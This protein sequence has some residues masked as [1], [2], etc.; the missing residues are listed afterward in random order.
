MKPPVEAPTSRQR[1]PLD[2]E[3]ELLQRVG[4]LD[5]AARDEARR[6]VDRDLDV[7][8]DELAGLLR[9]LAARADAHLPRHHGRSGA[10][11]R[12]EQA[13]LG[14]EGVKAHAGH[15]AQ[16]YLGC[17]KRPGI[18]EAVI[19]RSSRSGHGPVSL[20]EALGGASNALS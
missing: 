16:R 1:R 18:D 15:G 3:P 13:A 14:Q 11:A 20:A 4:E 17:A 19:C 12:L 6:L 5:P 8:I 10:G 7:G 9:A 2:V